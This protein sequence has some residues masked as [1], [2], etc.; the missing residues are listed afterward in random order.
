M[1]FVFIAGIFVSVV[2]LFA[3]VKLAASRGRSQAFWVL[4]VLMMPLAFIVLLML[5]HQ[6]QHLS[7]VRSNNALDDDEFFKRCTNCNKLYDASQPNCT[8]CG[9]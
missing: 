1:D 3:T 8:I 2:L 9:F 5:P 7:N 6:K 4:L